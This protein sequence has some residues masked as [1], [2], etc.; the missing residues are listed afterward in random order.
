MLPV[1]REA[2]GMAVAVRAPTT[3]ISAT[4]RSQPPEFEGQYFS[5]KPAPAWLDVARKARTM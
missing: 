1:R 5:A 4:W 3:L 2:V